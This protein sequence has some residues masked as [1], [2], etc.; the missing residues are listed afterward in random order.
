[1]M[2]WQA[3]FGTIQGWWSDEERK[4]EIEK[5]IK[6]KATQTKNIT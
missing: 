4:E 5:E 2:Q 3:G 1:M 6:T